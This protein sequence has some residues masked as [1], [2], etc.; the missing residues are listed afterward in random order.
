M[1]KKLSI[2]INQS[3]SKGFSLLE[4]L[5]S[6]LLLA[7][8]ISIFVQLSYGNI[9][10]V[11]KARQLEKTASLLEQKMLQLEEEFKGSKSPLEEDEGEFKEEQDYFWSYKTQALTLP[12]TDVLMSLFQVPD[13]ETN[14]QMLEVMNG[15]L[16]ATVLELKLTVH[17]RGKRQKAFSYSL[18]SYFINYLDA[19][20]LTFKY[21]SDL[22]PRGAGL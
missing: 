17:Y 20:D 16:F 1:D 9:R 13:N 19:E 22:W 10:R 5:I 12:S 4:V 6:V 11:K 21:L 15:V 8:L 3:K 14:R 2:F 7:S 18:S